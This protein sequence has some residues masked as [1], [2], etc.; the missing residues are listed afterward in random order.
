MAEELQTLHAVHY[1]DSRDLGFI[2]D[3]SVHLVVTSPPY[4]M[5]GM[6]DEQFSSLNPEIGEAL[7]A[8]DGVKAFCIMHSELDKVWREVF[9]VL[10]PGG[11]LCIIIGDATRKIGS[12]FRLYP[13]QARITHGCSSIGFE[14]LPLILWWKPTNAPNKFM[15]SGMLPAG[16]YVTLEHEYIVVLRKCGKR[17]FKTAREKENRRQSAFFWEERNLWFSDRWDDIRGT[18][19]RIETE[20]V[21]ERSAAFPL[22]LALRLV[23]M[24]SVA[25][26]TVLDP[27]LGTGTLTIAS[28]VCGRNSI[29]CELDG[30]FD[31]LIRNNIDGIRET[32]NR[33]IRERLNAHERFIAEYELRKGSPKYRNT[34]HGF[35]VV[36]G[37]ETDIRLR[38]IRHIDV[39]D[40][41]EY[42]VEYEDI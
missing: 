10:V 39:V 4:P 42:K 30:R 19:Q 41:G 8:C 29:G 28:M 9:R 3:E 24:H 11:L 16:A 7:E 12:E 33:L 15:G 38:F 27:F 13:N 31:S 34:F 1:A 25:G 5:I 37:Q 23:C 6:W 14:V 17:E 36:T 22:D 40:T 21:R 32:G 2:D 20:E 26:D 35:P 18:K